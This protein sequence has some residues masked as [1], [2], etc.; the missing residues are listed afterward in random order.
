MK[1]FPSAKSFWLGC[2]IWGLVLISM[3]FTFISSAAELT[4]AQWIINSFI[5]LVIILFLGIIW[6]GTGY[7][8]DQDLLIVKIGPITHSKIKISGISRIA[9]TRS[10]ISAPANSFK[11]LAIEKDNGVEVIISPRDEEFFISSIKDV[12]PNIVI[13]LK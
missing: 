2:I 4:Q 6:F 13:V 9:R 3:G 5:Y 1:Y 8:I 7:Y 11:R 10:I 12:N